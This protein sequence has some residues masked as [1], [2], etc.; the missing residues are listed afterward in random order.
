MFYSSF[1]TGLYGV[2]GIFVVVIGAFK[3]F[4]IL[5]LVLETAHWLKRGHTAA[6]A[7]WLQS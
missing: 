1:T 6:T 3:C 7:I 4:L 2:G 5:V